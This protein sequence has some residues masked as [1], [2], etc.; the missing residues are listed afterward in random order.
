VATEG[1]N[2]S[3][4]TPRT[5][6]PVIPERDA[7]LKDAAQFLAYAGHY[8]SARLDRMLLSARDGAITGLILAGLGILVLATAIVCVVLL[9]EG[10]AG[11]LGVALNGALWGGQLIVGGG[12]LL[13][14]GLTV[15]IVLAVVNAK[16]RHARI[17][18]YEKLKRNER[19]RF[20]HDVDTTARAAQ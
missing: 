9:L 15:L 8:T 6:R 1:G 10:F 16:L 14:I 2:G 3:G 7:M 12:I 20:G 11:G 13:L 4:S 17:E 5:E 18:K 19:A